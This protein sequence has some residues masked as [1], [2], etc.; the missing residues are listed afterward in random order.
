[1]T[2]EFTKLN[3]AIVTPI[4]KSK[5]YRKI[6]PY[7][8]G[9]TF[10]HAVYKKQTKEISIVFSVHHYD[11]PDIGVTLRILYNEKQVFEKLYPVQEGGLS[12]IMDLVA[13]DLNSEETL[14]V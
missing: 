2:T 13:K 5:G 9:A 12:V 4:L 8:Y 7:E 6:G 14:G 1:M 3:H 10:D 11:Y